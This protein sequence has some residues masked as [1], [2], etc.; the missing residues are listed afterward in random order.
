MCFAS[1]LG[2]RHHP[3]VQQLQD[4]IRDLKTATVDN[5]KLVEAAESEIV[6]RYECKLCMQRPIDAVIIPCGHALACRQCAVTLDS[7]PVC[8]CVI[9]QLTHVYFWS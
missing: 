6:R 3:V 2:T 4:E 7:C 1:C 8:R 9:K 5:W